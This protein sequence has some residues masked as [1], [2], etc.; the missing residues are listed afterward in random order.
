MYVICFYWQGDRWQQEEFNS[1]AGHLNLQQQHL[2][3]AGKLTGDLASRYVNNL[4]RGVKQFA[5]RPFQFICFTNE[6][7]KVVEGVE[8][9]PFKQVTLDGVLPRLY[10]FSQ[11]AGLFGHQVLCLDLDVVVVGPL[12]R[13]MDYSGLFC[14]RMSFR[15]TEN[16]Y[17]LD[18]DV[19]SF[20]AGKETEKIFWDPFIRNVPLAEGL[21]QGRERLWIRHVAK[22]IANI[23]EKVAPKRVVSYKRH[24]QRY[25]RVPRL[26]SIVSFH[27]VPRPHQVKNRWIK[28][29][30]K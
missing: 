2:N 27:G 28:Q 21:T 12:K 3:R 14:T 18:G 19:M 10:M 26:A 24:V 13:L 29:Y 7:L 17:E 9:R 25:G 22:D 15:P 20:T 4:Y 5:S 23:W 8:I 6:P 30:W 16:G 1:P 11:E